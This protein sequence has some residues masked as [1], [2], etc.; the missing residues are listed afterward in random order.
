ME[1]FCTLRMVKTMKP[2]G[3]WDLDTRRNLYKQPHAKCK[4]A[5]GLNLFFCD[6]NTQMHC[7]N[8]KS[9]IT[10]YRDRMAAKCRLLRLVQFLLAISHHCLV[11]MSK[12]QVY[13]CDRIEYAV[14]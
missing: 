1:R 14:A 3:L 13:F 2:R 8:Y 5:Y 11:D 10:N 9:Y 4:G 6:R 12:L 7:N